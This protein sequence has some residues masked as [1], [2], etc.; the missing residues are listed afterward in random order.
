ML[1]KVEKKKP[2][3]NLMNSSLPS[4]IQV[5]CKSVHLFL[6]SLTNKHTNPQGNKAGGGGKASSLIKTVVL[7]QNNC[8][9]IAVHVNS[10][11]VLFFCCPVLQ[12]VKPS[13]ACVF[14]PFPVQEDVEQGADSPVR[15]EPLW[16]PGV[17]VHLQHFLGWVT[18]QG[19]S[20]TVHVNKTRYFIRGWTTTAWTK[21]EVQHKQTSSYSLSKN[22]FLR[23]SRQATRSGDANPS[24]PEGQGGEEEQAHVSNQRGEKAATL[25]QPHKL[26]HPSLWSE[27]WDRGWTR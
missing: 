6:C 15:D 17:R 13:S 4:H 24:E 8:W 19:W 3:H 5:S 9:N 14:V 12:T 23:L 20:A 18:T 11:N 21:N 2:H 10:V 26:Q 1:K 27:D 7:I 25:H 22:V 16:E